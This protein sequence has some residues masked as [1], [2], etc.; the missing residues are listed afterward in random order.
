MRS[1]ERSVYLAGPISG[2]TY[3]GATDWREYAK[4]KLETHGITAY[5]PM[6]GKEYL[7]TEKVLQGHPD[8][9]VGL[10]LSN[11]KGIVTRDRRDCQACD[12]VIMNLLPAEETGIVSIGSM[13]EVGWAD[14]IRVPIIV[15]MTE[16]NPH[17]HAMLTEIA[18]YVV[19]T[20]DDAIIVAAALLNPSPAVDLAGLHSTPPRVGETLTQHALDRVQEYDPGD[21]GDAGR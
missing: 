9:Y 3:E 16:K 20:L 8:A 21:S 10:G 18:G 13:I 17:Y 14:S 12:I 15:V 5:S 7:R 2:C 11:P 19:K 1:P 4:W 6:R